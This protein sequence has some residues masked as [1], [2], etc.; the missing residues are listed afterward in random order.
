MDVGNGEARFLVVPRQW[1]SWITGGLD[2]VVVL[3]SRNGKALVLECWGPGD[4][5]VHAGP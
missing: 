4:T 5:V 3:D 2:L 1:Q